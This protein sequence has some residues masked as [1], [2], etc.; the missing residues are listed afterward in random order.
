MQKFNVHDCRCKCEDI[1]YCPSQ[2]IWDDVN[3][4]CKCR[5]KCPE[6]KR[7]D[8]DTCHCL[9]K[10]SPVKRLSGW[11]LLPQSTSTL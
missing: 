11:I 5:H 8:G 6:G 3:C 4:R 1:Q 2:K 10:D 7:Q 9:A